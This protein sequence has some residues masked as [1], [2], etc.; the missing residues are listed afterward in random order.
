MKHYFL[1]LI[2]L[3]LCSCTSKTEPKQEKHSASIVGVWTVEDYYNKDNFTNFWEFKS[4][5]T[6]NELKYERDNSN[7]LKPD[8]NGVWVYEDSILKIT[9][10]GEDI[11]GK[12]KLFKQPQILTFKVL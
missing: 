11:N 2:S 6:F 8:E 1:I 7:V 5:Y 9:V 12:Y 4:D 10:K 3:I